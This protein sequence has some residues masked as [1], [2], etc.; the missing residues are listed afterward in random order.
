MSM[1]TAQGL[2]PGGSRC[3]QVLRHRGQG[4]IGSK[5]TRVT[6]HKISDTCDAA[7][8]LHP[9]KGAQHEEI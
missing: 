7:K 1:S 6:V 9:I 8:S 4:A 5:P 2:L 3:A